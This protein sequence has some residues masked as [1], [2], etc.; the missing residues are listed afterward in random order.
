MQTIR[1]LI[2]HLARG[3][4]IRRK[5]SKRFGEAQIFVTPECA[6]RYLHPN[7][8]AVD[9]ILLRNAEEFITSGSCVWDVGANVGILSF[10]ACGLAGPNGNVFAIEPD[11]YLVSLLRRSAR[12]NRQNNQLAPVTVIPSAVFD[13]LSLQNFNIAEG[14][15]ASNHLADLGSSQ[16]GGVRES[17]NT[18]TVTLDWLATQIREPDLIK[19]DTEGADFYVLRGGKELLKRK[20]PI[21]LFEAYDS[22]ASDTSA[23]LS[24][25]G[26]TLFNADLP[27]ES[28]RPLDRAPYYA[29][30]IHA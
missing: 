2:E 10:A 5:F 20:K 8:E 11:T 27:V 3:R 6:L 14:G 16:T 22:T 9:P 19:I 18:I 4:V 30:A 26:Y 21:L 7:I 1:K 24:D 13:S 12:V 28:R 29:L 23:F 25:L 17:Q 15:R